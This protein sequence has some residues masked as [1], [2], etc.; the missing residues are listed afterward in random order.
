MVET[1]E[2]N[3]MINCHHID[4]DADY[5]SRGAPLSRYTD[6][7]AIEMW[8]NNFRGFARTG[9]MPIGATLSDCCAELRR[10]R[11]DQ[12]SG[13][14]HDVEDGLLQYFDENTDECLEMLERAVA[15]HRKERERKAQ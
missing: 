6:A 8:A 13:L 5:L 11:V 10:R 14:V 3:A 7:Q 2:I 12:P 1:D 9:D 15:E 4:A